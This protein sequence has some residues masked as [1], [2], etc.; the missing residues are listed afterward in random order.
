[1]RVL[2]NMAVEEGKI[3]S[4]Y[5]KVAEAIMQYGK[6]FDSPDFINEMRG[7]LGLPPVTSLDRTEIKK[8]LDEVKALKSQENLN[9]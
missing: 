4:F 3:N 1:M 6:I 2:R 8:I 5:K 9:K 7:D